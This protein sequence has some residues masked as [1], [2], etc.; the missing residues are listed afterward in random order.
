MTIRQALDE[1]RLPPL[2][3]REEMLHL[4]EQEV[5]GPLPAPVP[6]SGQVL[7]TRE[8][9]CAGKAVRQSVRLSLHFA[10]GDFCMPILLTLP[11]VQPKALLFHLSFKRELPNE[12]CLTEEIVDSGYAVC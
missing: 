10:D 9:D 5:F 1:L 8:D 3:D 4:F 6:V 2:R 11:R 12:Y 7:E